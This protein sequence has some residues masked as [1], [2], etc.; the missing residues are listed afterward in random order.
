M[1][2]IRTIKPEFWTDEKIVQLPFHARLLF[3][4]MWNFADDDGRMKDHPDRIKMQVLPNDDIDITLTIDILLAANLIERW[5]GEEDSVLVIKGF[6]EHQVVSH[7]AKSKIELRNYKKSTIPLAERRKL[8]IKYGCDDGTEYMNAEC[9]FCG[10]AGKIW[11][12]RKSNG[13]PSYWVA[14][15]KLEIDHFVPEYSGGKTSSDNFVLSCRSC[16]RGRCSKDAIDYIEEKNN[17]YKK[18]GAIQNNQNKSRWG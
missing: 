5:H 8:A 18:S 1:A 13:E 12:P 6:K 2:R 15:S 17:L 4:G 16:N 3:I 14:F 11:W 9:F 10:S 7:P